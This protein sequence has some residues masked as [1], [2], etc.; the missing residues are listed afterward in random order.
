MAFNVR[1]P[2]LTGDY[3]KDKTLILNFMKEANLKIRLLED[4]LRKEIQANGNKKG[5]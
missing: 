4:Q 2:E 1:I 3:E 5:I